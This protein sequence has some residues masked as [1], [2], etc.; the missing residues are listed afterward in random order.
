M[1][2]DRLLLKT[3]RNYV[4]E[5]IS[6]SPEINVIS[7]ANGSGKT[8]ILEAIYIASHIKSFRNCTDKDI[9]Q[10]GKH[11]YYISVQVKNADISTIEIGTSVSDQQSGKKVKIDGKEIKKL[12]DFYGKINVVAF[13]PDDTVIISGTPDV[14]RRYF[15]RLISKVDKEYIELLTSFRKILKNRNR[16]LK[17]ILYKRDI[18]KQLDIWDSMYSDCAS[19]LVI[20]RKQYIEHFNTYFK[21]L[22]KELS[23]F[24]DD[25][26]IKY[27]ASLHNENV[28]DVKNELSKKRNIDIQMGTTTLG[29]HRDVYVIYG[30]ENTMFKSYA[31]T[32][33]RRLAS[34]AMKL[35]EV[36]LIY[37]IKK[38]KSIVLLDDVLSELDDDRR[39]NVLQKLI[40]GNHQVII[41]CA[42]S[43]DVNFVDNYK[44]LQVV[45]NRVSE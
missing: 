43:N 30:N 41:T 17:D 20:K 1:F 24:N 16:L 44:H 25:L 5:T 3:F 18:I 15:D 7:G 39:K 32:G 11:E 45:H 13:F 10:W 14:I 42:S 26:T 6:F 31:S 19:A 28:T 12:S 36:S 35:S 21:T 40:D 23:G 4:H 29:P 33:Q 27:Y 22:Y 2:I 37:D 8:N 34:I 38:S 9:I